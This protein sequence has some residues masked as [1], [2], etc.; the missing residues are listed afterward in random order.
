MRQSAKS[1]E[2]LGILSLNTTNPRKLAADFLQMQ[3]T[4]QAGST[5][6]CIA[7]GKPDSRYSVIG[8]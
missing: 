5:M 7:E 1:A 2:N 6:S 4:N 8:R 3:Q